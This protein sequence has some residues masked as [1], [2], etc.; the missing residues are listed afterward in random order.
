MCHILHNKVNDFIIIKSN[1][2]GVLTRHTQFCYYFY[3]MSRE[4]SLIIINFI[5]T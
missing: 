1:I 3:I 5:N 4:I 2:K